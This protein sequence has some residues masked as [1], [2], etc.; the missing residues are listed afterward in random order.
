MAA[1]LLTGLVLYVGSF[2]PV[3]WLA[4]RGKLPARNAFAIA[5]DPLIQLSEEYDGPIRWWAESLATP[6]CEHF[7]YESDRIWRDLD[8]PYR[9]G[10]FDPPRRGILS[11]VQSFFHSPRE[12]GIPKIARSERPPSL[13]KDGDEDE[14]S[15]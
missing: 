1:I 11:R 5:F 9:Q 4:S 6:R 14:A 12:Y 8:I 2:G 13:D 7:A 15:D 10:S 3:W